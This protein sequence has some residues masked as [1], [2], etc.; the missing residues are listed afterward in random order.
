MQVTGAGS[1]FFGFGL[2]ANTE[3]LAH[4]VPACD[5]H[6][7]F[8]LGKFGLFAEYIWSTRAFDPYDLSFNCRGAQPSAS[9][10]ELSYNLNSRLSRFYCRWIWHNI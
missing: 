7:E 4:P 10:L 5:I 1:G 8:S 3:I 6:G 9:N 2:N